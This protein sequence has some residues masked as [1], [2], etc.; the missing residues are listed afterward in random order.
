MLAA[1]LLI[2]WYSQDATVTPPVCMSSF[3]AAA[4]AGAE[5]MKRGLQG[6][7]FA[8]GLYII[9][10]LFVYTPLLL[11][12]PFWTVVET[13]ISCAAGIVASTMCI[14]GYLIQR[15]SIPERIILAGSAYALFHPGLITDFLGLALFLLCILIQ[16]IRSKKIAFVSLPGRK[17]DA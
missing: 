6:W 5:R 12:G 11:N 1:H 2:L 13:V 16:M 7:R 8:K 17:S 10:F 3:T 9:P 4:I 15:T 14:E